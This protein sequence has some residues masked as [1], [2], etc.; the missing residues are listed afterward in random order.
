MYSE[1]I[2]DDEDDGDLL[3]TSLASML[4][5]DNEDDIIAAAMVLSRTDGGDVRRNRK[6][7]WRY[8]CIVWHAA[9]VV[10]LHQYLFQRTYR[11]LYIAFTKLQDLLSDRIQLNTCNTPVKDPISVQ[12]VM[13]SGLRWLAGCPCLDIRISMGISLPSVYC[14]R[15]MFL[16]FLLSIQLLSLT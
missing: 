7:K 1:C 4:F 6:Q 11:M 13:A 15:D 3:S 16:V 12:I 9:H 14:F 2:L 8:T 10:Q 5:D